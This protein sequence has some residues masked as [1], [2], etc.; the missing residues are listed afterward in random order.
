MYQKDYSLLDKINVQSDVVVINQCEKSEEHKFKHK[1]YNIQWVNSIK[2][3]LSKSRNDAIKKA[4]NDICLLIDGDLVYI[5]K[6]D[7]IIIEQFEKHP[8]ADMIA[9]QVYGIEKEF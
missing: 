2:R 5:D 8:E 6:Y 1:N 7:K 9:F 3:G 4:N